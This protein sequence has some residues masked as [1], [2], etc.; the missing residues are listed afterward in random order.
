VRYPVTLERGRDGS[1]LAWVD[2]LPGCFV[3]GR[4][5]EE[6]H[7]RLPGAIRDFLL[8]AG[9]PV[10]SSIEIHVAGEVE[11]AIETDEDTEV[12]LDVDH[13][14]LTA[15]HWAMLEE[16]LERSRAELLARVARLEEAE[17]DR[18]PEG[19]ERTLREE[20]EHIAFVEL[21]YAAWTFDLRSREGL[22]AFLGW[23]RALAVE[24]M[25]SLAAASS[26]EA[27]EAEWAGAPRPEPWTPR[28][29][30]RRLVWHERLH[31]H[32]LG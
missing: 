19:S 7:E 10:P 3:R 30:A 8:W 27:T 13:E 14:P 6:A 31:L 23:T 11:S 32:K 29:A 22:T 4:S 20:L 25:R 26:A 2:E 21:M 5:P 16:W 28:K 1:V 15:A 24:R 18:A 12:L 17:L 9:E